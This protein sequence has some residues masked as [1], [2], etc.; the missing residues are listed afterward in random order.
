MNRD[1]REGATWD[2]RPVSS[3]RFTRIVRW[4]VVSTMGFLAFVGLL[5]VFIIAMNAWQLDDR[6]RRSW[7]ALALEAGAAEAVPA[8]AGGGGVP[9]PPPRLAS[10]DGCAGHETLCATAAT[11][12][13]GATLQQWGAAWRASEA[14]RGEALPGSGGGGA[15]RADRVGLTG[16]RPSALPHHRTCGFPHP[17]VEPSGLSPRAPTVE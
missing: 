1:D 16:L 2:A 13:P 12:D 8:L 3:I 9:V 17:A 14:R 10:D 5:A 7:P 6:D 15:G 4:V 11:D